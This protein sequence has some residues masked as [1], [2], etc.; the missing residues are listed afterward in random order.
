MP[1]TPPARFGHDAAN[2][3]NEVQKHFELK[4]DT[5]VIAVGAY[6]QSEETIPVHRPILS[7]LT[8]TRSIQRS[9]C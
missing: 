8:T 7:M 6:S 9:R 4:Y 3:N 1:A 2:T 5:L